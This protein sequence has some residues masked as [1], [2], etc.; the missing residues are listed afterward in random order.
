MA[1]L[2]IVP[3]EDDEFSLEIYVPSGDMWMN[4]ISGSLAEALMMK[5]RIELVVQSQKLSARA[6]ESGTC[7]VESGTPQRLFSF[8]DG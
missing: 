4:L 7:P 3:V 8:S 5:E 2:R 6:G 1:K